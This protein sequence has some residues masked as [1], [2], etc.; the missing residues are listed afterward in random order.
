[1]SLWGKVS[2]I[3]YSDVQHAYDVGGGPT[4]EVSMFPMMRGKKANANP[5]RTMSGKAIYNPMSNASPRPGTTPPSVAA[6]ISSSLASQLFILLSR[7]SDATASSG[8]DSSAGSSDAL[9]KRR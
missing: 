9:S 1:M 7:D 4:L 3:T 2:Y 8:V 5:E 6:F